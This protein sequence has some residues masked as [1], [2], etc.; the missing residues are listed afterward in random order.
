MTTV[1]ISSPGSGDSYHQ[2]S[3]VTL[4]AGLSSDSNVEKVEFYVDGSMVG[5]DVPPSPQVSWTTGSKN[6]HNSIMAKALLSDGSSVSSSSVSIKVDGVDSKWDDGTKKVTN[7]TVDSGAFHGNYAINCQ[8]KVSLTLG[9]AVDLTVGFK[10]YNLLGGSVAVNA[11]PLFT[12]LGL[13]NTINANIALESN[14]NSLKKELTA[15]SDEVKAKK[16]EAELSKSQTIADLTTLVVEKC[17][18]L[19]SEVVAVNER[20]DTVNDQLATK[21]DEIEVI[22]E[23]ILA[24][25]QS[26]ETVETQITEKV[27]EIKSTS[28]E[29]AEINTQLWSTQ[30]A[31]NECQSQINSGE[32][33]ILGATLT[34]MGE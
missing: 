32:I 34:M 16:Y 4:K 19:N 6:A 28:N 11:G 33:A 10:S 8:N 20:V 30:C 21:N 17:S 31:I 7:T 29:L 14:F 18:A 9:S 5:S 27:N 2:S 1:T 22:N 23:S 24:V 26:I 12:N 13:T 15:D 3:A 25:N